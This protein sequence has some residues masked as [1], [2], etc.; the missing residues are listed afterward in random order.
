MRTITGL[1]MM[2]CVGFAYGQRDLTF[3][4][5]QLDAFGQELAIQGATQWVTTKRYCEGRTEMFRMRDG[6]WC[7]SKGTYYASY[8]FWLE[9]PAKLKMRKFDNCGGFDLKTIDLPKDNPIASLFMSFDEIEKEEVLDYKTAVRNTQPEQ[10]TAIYNCKRDFRFQKDGKSFEKHFSLFDLSNDSDQ[11]N[12]N[13]ERNNSLKLAQ[14]NKAID[15]LLEQ[16]DNK[17]TRSK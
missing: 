12:L 14:L 2:L 3:V 1:L 4:E 7:S 13:Y 17:L 5:Q 8:V 15:A 11:A 10:R 16:Y 9:T 6:S